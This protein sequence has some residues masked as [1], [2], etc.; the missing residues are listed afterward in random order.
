[1][2]QRIA[3]SKVTFRS[4]VRQLAPSGSEESKSVAF[5][6]ERRRIF[7]EHPFL[8]I[9]VD[10]WDDQRFPLSMIESVRCGDGKLKGR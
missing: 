2:S 4:I 8:V 9:E 1:V 3:V 7:L 6:S 10:G 5:P